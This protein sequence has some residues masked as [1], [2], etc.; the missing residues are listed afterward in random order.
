VSVLSVPQGGFGSRQK[1]LL[2]VVTAWKYKLG[3]KSRVNRD[4]PYYGT[5]GG[6]KAIGLASREKVLGDGNLPIV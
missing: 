3:S 2:C 4:Q 5:M 6:G 1:N